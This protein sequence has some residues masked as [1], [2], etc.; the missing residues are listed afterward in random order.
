MAPTERPILYSAPMVRSLLRE[1]D[2]KT[3][4]RRIVKWRGMAPGLN[5]GFSGLHAQTYADGATLYSRRGD[6]CWEERTSTTPCPYGQPGDRLWVKEAFR[7]T[8]A[9]DGDSPARVAERCLDAGYSAPWAPIQYEA[10]GAR[11]DWMHV[12]TPPHAGPPRVGKTRVSI[13]M[14][15]WASRITLEITEVR[16][17]RLQEI[18]EEDAIAEGIAELVPQPNRG[19][20]LTPAA[21]CLAAAATVEAMP[22]TTRRGFLAGALA[23]NLGFAVSPSRPWEV[24]P[25][26]W[27]RPPT[28]QQVY[29]VLWESINGPGSWAANPWVWAISFTRVR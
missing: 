16:V 2:P 7:L 24:V 13:H 5:L 19:E 12:G 17:Q 22:R 4:T 21:L 25:A 20:G 26:R 18:S 6:G 10:D 27:T 29:A 8:S 9:F 11:R 14:P 3:Q 23:A 28:A 15:R 1:V